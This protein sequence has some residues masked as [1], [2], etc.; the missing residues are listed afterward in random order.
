V[1]KTAILAWKCPCGRSESPLNVIGTHILVTAQSSDDRF[2]SATS[3][4]AIEAVQVAQ[5]LDVKAG[6][7]TVYAAADTRAAS[8][9][10]AGLRGLPDPQ[11][12]RG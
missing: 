6:G 12:S 5:R 9:T 1:P 10:R 2:G 4:T 8:S 11:Q 7:G 3:G